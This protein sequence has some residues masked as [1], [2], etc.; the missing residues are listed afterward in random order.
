MSSLPLGPL[1]PCVLEGA[2][3][4]LEPLRQTHGTG[5]LAAA[6]DPSIWR[7]MSKSLTDAAAVEEFIDSALR[8]E[9]A[10]RAYAFAV[11]SR[12]DG[13]VIGSTRYLDVDEANRGAEVGWTFYSRAAWGGA[14]NPESK[15]LLLRH[16]FEDWGAMRIALRTDSRNLHSQAAIRK[17]GARYEGLLRS[18]RLRRDGSV[19]DTVCF[20]VVREEWP[21]VRAGLLARLTNETP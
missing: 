21:S 20:S 5:I 4:R 12:S 8:D 18:H 10:G 2:A 7:W 6:D 16:A 14:V 13:N 17:L 15:L 9:A 3:V 1:G 19:R 11:V